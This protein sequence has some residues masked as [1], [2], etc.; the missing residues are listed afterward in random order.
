MLWVMGMQNP[1]V[2]I[3]HWQCSWSRFAVSNIG[4]EQTA[5]YALPTTPITAHTSIYSGSEPAPF[6]V[7]AN[8]DLDFEEAP[9]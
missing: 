9:A 3:E 8:F 1:F 5:M 6:R 4:I 2:H 7:N